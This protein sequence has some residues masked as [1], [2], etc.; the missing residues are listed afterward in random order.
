MS[1]AKIFGAKYISYFRI[2]FSHTSYV[3]HYLCQLLWSGERCVSDSLPR[4][5]EGNEATAR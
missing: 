4:L 5:S 2:L 3:E 1:V